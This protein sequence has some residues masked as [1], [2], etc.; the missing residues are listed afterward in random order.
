MVRP[1]FSLTNLEHKEVK[2]L[3]Q[4]P[5]GRAEPFPLH[6]SQAAQHTW[7]VQSSCVPEMTHTPSPET[8]TWYVWESLL[9]VLRKTDLL[10]FSVSRETGF[11]SSKAQMSSRGWPGGSH[12]TGPFFT[13]CTCHNVMWIPVFSILTS[14]PLPRPQAS[15][16]LWIMQA[17][18]QT[19]SWQ[20]SSPWLSTPKVLLG[21][22]TAFLTTCWYFSQA[23]S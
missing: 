18:F 8:K 19:R 5:Q 23:T 16:T 9:T 4:L 3:G 14:P 1:Q 20:A 22:C 13:P 6:W 2:V 7:H 15:V 11:S 10:L 17:E 21:P 12:W